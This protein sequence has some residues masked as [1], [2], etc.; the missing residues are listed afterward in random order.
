MKRN[1]YLTANGRLLRKESTLHFVNREGRT[2]IPVEQVKAIYAVGHITLTSGVISFLSS[3]GIPI[4]FFGHYGNF[5]GSFY[6]RRRLISGYAVVNQ[7]EAYLDADRRLLIAGEIVHASI[8]N[9]VHTCRQHKTKGEPLSPAVDSLEECAEEIDDCRSVPELMSVEGRA[10]GIYYETFDHII[11]DFEMGPRVRRPPNN[12]VNALI[13]FG[14]SLLYSAVLTQL[15]HTQ[16]DPSISY[17]HEPLER[18]YSLALDLAEVFKPVL[19]DSVIFYVL[20][21]KLITAED[22]NQELNSCLLA[23]TGRRTFIRKFEDRLR[24]TARHPRLK[25]KVSREYLLRLDAYKLL[26]HV[27]EGSEYSPYLARRGW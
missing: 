27:C 9:M 18:R 6:P 25:R 22:F 19:V 2:I 15:Y 26:K 11:K 4:H 17:L 21:L 16:L 10:W 23:D 13:S 12:P 7:A 1:L 20:N 5:E 14:N 8:Q 24:E 3:L